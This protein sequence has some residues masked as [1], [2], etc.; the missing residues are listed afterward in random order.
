[1][2]VRNDVWQRPCCV[3]RS[4]RDGPG[5]EDAPEGQSF[6][7]RVPA[8]LY[9][10]IRRRGVAA[11]LNLLV[12]NKV[13][14]LVDVRQ[15]AFSFKKGFSKK[16]LQ[17]ELGRIG[18]SYVH[19]PLLGTDQESRREYRRTGDFDRLAQMYS[20]RLDDNREHYEGLKNLTSKESVAMM[21]FEDDFS[22][23]HRSID[24]GETDR[25]RLRGGS[26]ME[27][28]RRRVLVTVKAYPERSEHH[29][30]VDRSRAAF[31]HQTLFG[32]DRTL[33]ERLPRMFH[34]RF[35]CSP[36]CPSAH[37]MSIEDWEVFESFSIMDTKYRDP[38]VLWCKMH[39]RCFTDFAASDL[40][41]FVGTHSRW[42][43]WMV[44]GA[45]YPPRG[46]ASLPI[47]G[48]SAGVD[49]DCHVT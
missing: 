44:I 30:E 36:S 46:N 5:T 31:I 27:W 35:R 42:P 34:Y 43:V 45:F 26:P 8:G 39:Q 12:G 10:R 37:D 28:R 6:G 32:D 15:N 41:F 23:C 11:F 38:D 48:V 47:E 22:R 14:L 7:P 49:R 9:D 16:P 1:M 2:T 25:G 13:T 19:M 29:G 17:T 21:C 24:R 18:I 4:G 33:L 20:K 3:V 40:Y